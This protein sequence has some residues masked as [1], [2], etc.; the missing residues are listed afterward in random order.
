[1]VQHTTEFVVTALVVTTVLAVPIAFVD[2]VTA[3]T[4]DDYRLCRRQQRERS[5]RRVV[6]RL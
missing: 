1:M 4:R 5:N 3:S 2:V 6:R